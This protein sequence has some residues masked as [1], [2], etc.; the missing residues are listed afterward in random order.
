VVSQTSPW[1]RPADVTGS[2]WAVVDV[3]TSGFRPGQARIVSI[4]ALALGDDGNVE[5]SLYSLL[6]P[7]VDPGPTHVHGLTAEMLEGQPTFADIV[8]HLIDLLAG[9]T[10]VAHNVGF[11]YSFLAAEAEMVGREL[12]TDTVMCTVELARRLDLGTE[13]LRLETLARHWGIDQM[14]PHDALDDALV[15][16]QILKPVL[17]RA[18][19]RKV[20][21]PVHPVTRRTWPNGSVTHDELRPLKAV[22]ARMPCPYQNPGRFLPDR[23]LVQGMRVA[24]SSEVRRTHEELIER[25]LHAGLAYTDAVDPETSLVICNDPNPEQGKGYQAR[26][27]GVPLVSDE[28]FLSRIDGVVGGIGVEEFVDTATADGQLILF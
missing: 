5:Q 18:R 25:I 1:G 11:D 10:L 6:N 3:E 20:W 26:D 4:A 21:L 28:D 7:G 17:L 27:L 19:E 22:A 12:P 14:K 23:P 15:L 8:D 9:R 16:A 2:G 13:N 24:L